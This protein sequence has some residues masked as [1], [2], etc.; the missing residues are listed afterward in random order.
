MI[1]LWIVA[2]VTVTL[3]FIFTS[4]LTSQRRKKLAEEWGCR[5]LYVR[6]NKWPGGI[7]FLWELY[8]ADKNDQVPDELAK[9]FLESPS[10][11]WEVQLWGTPQLFTNNPKNIQAMLGTQFE[12][13]GVGDQRR[14]GFLPMLGDGIFTQDGKA[15]EHSRALLRPQFTRDQVG[16]LELEETHIQR[17]LMH[18]PSE[19]SGWTS[20]VDLGPL[21]FSLT[22]DSATEFLFG[23]STETLLSSLP[24]QKVSD[25]MLQ[26]KTVGEC[27]DIGTNTI[28]IRIRLFDLYFLYNPK[29]FR[30]SCKEI[31]RFADH[32]VKLAIEKE[33]EGNTASGEKQRYIFLHELVKVTK[34]P[35]VL[36]S[37]LLNILIAGRDT[38]AGLIGW[39]F[40]CLARNP[41]VFQKL[42]DTIIESFGTYENPHDISFST[43]KGCS[44]LQ[45][46]MNETLRLFP[47][48]PNNGRESIKDTTLPFGGGQ[49]GQSPVFIPK[50]HLCNYSVY[51]LHRR[52]DIWGLDAEE[53]NPDR[54]YG[55]KVGW[56]YLPFNGGPRICLGQ[57]FALTEAGYVI[58]RLVQK[59][60]RIQN[61]ESD[62]EIRHNFGVTSSP[63]R[64]F[65]RLHEAEK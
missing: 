41:K 61:C 29:S 11:T 39:T 34:D 30:D 1:P 4:L 7:E 32:F 26:W 33:K 17:F 42:R 2:S 54:W 12:D 62:K 64:V 22:L 44:Y 16:D 50:G 25:A 31:N 24:G 9:M 28:G 51:A 35:V 38:T 37:Q 18:I 47:S 57:Q 36:R 59:Y 49:D 53:Y 60:D 3:Y 56:E 46:T 19:S 10:E 40:W 6:P 48:V 5:P 65:V 58:T 14:R 63:K 15:W 43:L 27:F 21:F 23:Q 20:E 45:Y 13:F 55:L 52:K 8:Q